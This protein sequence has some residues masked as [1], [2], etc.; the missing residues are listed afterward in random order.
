MRGIDKNGNEFWCDTLDSP[1][2]EGIEILKYMIELAYQLG[3]IHAKK[4]HNI[5]SLSKEM[6][7][8][9]YESL[10]K[11]RS[12]NI[13]LGVSGNGN[14]REDGNATELYFR[15]FMKVNDIPIED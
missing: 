1:D 4:G 2:P 13:V 7:E 10:D 6:V 11:F 14:A 15:L 3:Y 12:E 5:E 9:M 8:D